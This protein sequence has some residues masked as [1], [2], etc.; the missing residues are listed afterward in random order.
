MIRTCSYLVAIAFLAVFS[1]MA[2][3]PREIVANVDG[4]NISAQDLREARRRNVG[5]TGR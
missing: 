4:E 5:E 2:Q 1:L 3:E